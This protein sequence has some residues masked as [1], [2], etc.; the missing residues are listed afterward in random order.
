M[1]KSNKDLENELD[2]L[3][4]A[5]ISIEELLVKKGLVSLEELNSTVKKSYT[6]CK[7]KR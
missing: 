2:I 4:S 6:E 3:H 1:K 5:V 7:K